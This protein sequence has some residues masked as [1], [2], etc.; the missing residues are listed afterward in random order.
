MK[1]LYLRFWHFH[2]YFEVLVRGP[3]SYML[4]TSKFIIY[5]HLQHYV[6]D[7]VC[8]NLLIWSD[9]TNHSHANAYTQTQLRTDLLQA[10]W[11][12]QRTFY[13][14]FQVSFHERASKPK[15]NKLGLRITEYLLITYTTHNSRSQL[16]WPTEISLPAALLSLCTV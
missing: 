11:T 13:F 7:C 2:M 9:E 6:S 12:L 8:T 10:M 1:V 16:C 4:V 3:H 15:L 14:H 5:F